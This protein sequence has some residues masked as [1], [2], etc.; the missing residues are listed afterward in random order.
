MER[1]QSVHQDHSPN[2][3]ELS[4]KNC[5]PKNTFMM[6]EPVNSIQ[7]PKLSSQ[8]ISLTLVLKGP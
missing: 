2:Y 3:L 8:V 1:L 4:E 6:P 7:E 5:L